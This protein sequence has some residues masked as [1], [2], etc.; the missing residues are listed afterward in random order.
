MSRLSPPIKCTNCQHNWRVG[1]FETRSGNSVGYTIEDYC[2]SCTQSSEV[3]RLLKVCDLCKNSLKFENFAH[4]Q[5][6]CNTCLDRFDNIGERVCETCEARF[7]QVDFKTVNT[8]ERCCPSCEKKQRTKFKIWMIFLLPFILYGC[9]S[10]L[11]DSNYSGLPDP[12]LDVIQ[13]R[14]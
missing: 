12:S 10:H 1:I 7:I 14:P 2:A 5:R 8:V 9:W 13:V 11:T 4:N 3:V 6:F